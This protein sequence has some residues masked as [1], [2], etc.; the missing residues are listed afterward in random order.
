MRW[1]SI[2]L[3]GL[4]ENLEA[5][6]ELTAHDGML[7]MGLGQRT[8]LILDVGTKKTGRE[9][10]LHLLDTIAIGI[11]KEKADHEIVKNTIDERLNNLMQTLFAELVV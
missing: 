10:K 3:E 6:G 9:L 11:A 7:A 8:A 4:A 5:S 2:L 1:N